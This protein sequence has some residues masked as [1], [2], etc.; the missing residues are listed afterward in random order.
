M[1][2][3]DPVGRHEYDDFKSTTERRL[4]GHDRLYDDMKDFGG[5]LR[6]L[7]E[8]MRTASHDIAVVEGDS[9]DPD[10]KCAKCRA[11]IDQRIDDINRWRW[12]TLGAIGAF[13]AIPTIVSCIILVRQ[14]AEGGL[15]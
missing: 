15:K 3:L 4:A 7:T 13:L 2:E 8:Q 10:G 5:A 6:E 9:R 1:A 11:T 14:L 12:K